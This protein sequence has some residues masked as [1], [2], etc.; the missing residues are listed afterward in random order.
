MLQPVANNAMW[1]KTIIETGSLCHISPSRM[2]CPAHVLGVVMV[3]VLLANLC[4]CTQCS[5][6]YSLV[7]LVELHNELVER[8]LAYI[9]MSL[10]PQVL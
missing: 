10:V 7:Q 1:C 2:G 8:A 6:V 9:Q 5:W 3:S 4:C